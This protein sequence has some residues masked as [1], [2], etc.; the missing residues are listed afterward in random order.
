MKVSKESPQGHLAKGAEDEMLIAIGPEGSTSDC[1][2]IMRLAV[3]Y[4]SRAANARSKRRGGQTALHRAAAAKRPDVAEALVM[5]GA[6]VDAREVQYNSTPLHTAVAKGAEGVV[7][8]LLKRGADPNAMCM[9]GKPLHIAAWSGHLRIVRTL[10][11]HGANTDA[12]NVSGATARD[13]ARQQGHD[14]IVQL[15]DRLAG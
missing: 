15:L 3:R 8:M 10:V 7:E 13:L 1:E 9:Y 6:E 12:P 4:G 5:N 2:A 14:Q 11:A